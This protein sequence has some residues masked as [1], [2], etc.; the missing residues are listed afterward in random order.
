MLTR[1]CPPKELHYGR[2]FDIIQLRVYLLV[3]HIIG[4]FGWRKQIRKNYGK[5]YEKGLSIL[6]Q[7]DEVPPNMGLENVSM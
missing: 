1:L 6:S 4:L 2:M 7:R 5:L 3:Y